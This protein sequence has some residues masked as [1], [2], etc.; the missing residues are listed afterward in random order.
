MHSH[1]GIIKEGHPINLDDTFFQKPNFAGMNKLLLLLSLLFNLSI[2][3]PQINTDFEAYPLTNG[4]FID[5]HP[6]WS[7]DG[8]SLVF[9]SNRSDYQQIFS[10]TLKDTCIK[11]LTFTDAINNN[12]SWHPDGE[13]IIFDSDLSGKLEIYALN[14]FQSKNTKLFN[15]NVEAWGGRLNS[16]SN[17]LVFSGKRPYEKQWSIYSYDFKYNNLNKITSHEG[18]CLFP[19]WSPDA[20][21]ISYFK[22]TGYETFTPAI[23][24][25]YG[26]E[27][28]ASAVK[29]P[30]MYDINWSPDGYK[31]VYVVKE[32]D[33]YKLY[34]SRRDGT[35][36]VLLATSTFKISQPEWS[37]A[38]DKVVF[39][40]KNDFQQQN[41]WLLK[42][43]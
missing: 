8:E 24:H 28:F 19:R 6:S 7:P 18:D 37:P 38:G 32:T 12:P 30:N 31:I 26:K 15:R 23:I 10:I 17:L 13:H 2:A 42:L 20:A 29:Q 22:Q 33:L 16:L 34:I 21:Y 41:I 4:H 35:E 36:K 14:L 5:S 43:Y 3:F 11:Q 9:A 39:C 25:W 40:L 1:N 27:T